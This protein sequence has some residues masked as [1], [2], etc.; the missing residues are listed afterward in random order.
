MIHPN[1]NVNYKGMRCT[2]FSS[3]MLKKIVPIVLKKYHKINVVRR[4]QMIHPYNLESN[5][6]KFRSSHNAFISENLENSSYQ[7]IGLVENIDSIDH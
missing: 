7:K 4:H 1:L 6:K 3:I 5:K 2:T